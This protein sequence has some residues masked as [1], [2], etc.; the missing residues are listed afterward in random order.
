MG[1]QVELFFDSVEALDFFKE[2]H[3]SIDL[4]VT[5]QTMPEKTGIELAGDLLKIRPDIPIILC[6][7]YAGT[8]NEAKTKEAGIKRLV[9]KP[10]TVEDLSI[11]IQQL[12][13]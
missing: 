10:V 12:L 2:S 11:E 7:G 9:M 5:D 4:V 6:S 3:H 8:I 1:Y 13:K